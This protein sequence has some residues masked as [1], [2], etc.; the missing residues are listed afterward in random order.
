MIKELRKVLPLRLQVS[1]L[2]LYLMWLFFQTYQPWQTIDQDILL[3]TGEF[4]NATDL[5]GWVRESGQVTW[6]DDTGFVSLNSKA[7][8]RFNLPTFAGD[9][10]VCSGRIKTQSVTSGKQQWDAGRIMVYFEDA[11]GHIIWSH[12]HDVGFLSGNEDW[13]NFTTMIEVPKFAKKG[14]IELAHYGKSGTVSFDDIKVFPAAW[15]PAFQH[16]QMFFGMLWA[17][18][19]MWLVLNTHFWSF[20]WGKAALASGVVIIIGVTLPPATMFQVASGGAKFSQEV[21]LKA[22]DVFPVYQQK[23]EIKEDVVVK[24]QSQIVNKTDQKKTVTNK[25]PVSHRVQSNEGISSKDV[26]KLG[27]AILFAILG[28]FAFI[29]FYKKVSLGILAY[30]LVLFAVSTEVLQLVIDGRLTVLNDLL[31]DIA[32]ISFGVANAWFLSRVRSLI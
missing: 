18:I 1:T 28:Y 13:V 14:W 29:A 6:S 20:A 8:L 3:N 12:P 26:Q 11:K 10:L 15:K 4:S 25:E 30:T 31:L 2:F 27:H 9:L 7:R 22:N 16:W 21:L 24:K 32:G 5:S 19:M 23:V 17:S